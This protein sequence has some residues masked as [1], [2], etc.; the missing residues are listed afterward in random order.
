MSGSPPGAVA[1][2]VVVSKVKVKKEIKT[3]VENLETILGDLRDVAKELK[4]VNKHGTGGSIPM[5]LN[6]CKD[7][8]PEHRARARVCVC[9]RAR[10]CGRWTG[11]TQT[12][13]H[14][15]VCDLHL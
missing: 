2:G 5:W 11:L 9:V 15:Y 4:E 1:E 8:P 6:L 10:A 14:T 3:I 12:Q 13:T 7:A